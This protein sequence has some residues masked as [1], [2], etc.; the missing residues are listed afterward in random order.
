MPR[1]RVAPLADTQSCATTE[2]TISGG[3]VRGGGQITFGTIVPGQG[4]N[5]FFALPGC[6]L[7]NQAP[8]WTGS[9]TGDRLVASLSLTVDCPADGRVQI[10]GRADGSRAVTN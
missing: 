1:R 10:T 3:V 9:V 4:S 2:G 7:V 6:V 8:Q 5:E